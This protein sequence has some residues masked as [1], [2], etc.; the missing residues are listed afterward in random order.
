MAPEQISAGANS[1]RVRIG[2]SS[3]G[4]RSAAPEGAAV[5]GQTGRGGR[6][7]V[8]AKANVGGPTAGTL[9]RLA[10]MDAATRK[11]ATSVEH[12]ARPLGIPGVPQ[13]GQTPIAIPMPSGI[14]RSK[15]KTISNTTAS[16]LGTHL[17]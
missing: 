14:T 16:V 5:E 1:N 12:I 15:I 13:S 17:R 10:K 11:P 3:M 9:R 8:R 2:T 4:L 6:R 7:R